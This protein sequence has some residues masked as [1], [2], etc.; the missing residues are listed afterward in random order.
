MNRREFVRS[1]SKAAV[2]LSVVVIAAKS[3][4]TKRTAKPARMMAC[5]TDASGKNRHKL[6]EP[7]EPMVIN[8]KD[9]GKEI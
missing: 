3:L 7:G 5:W 8:G 6:F 1:A 2:R 9:Y 4:A